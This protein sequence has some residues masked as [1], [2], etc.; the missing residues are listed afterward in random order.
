MGQYLD[1]PQ[2]GQPYHPGFVYVVQMEGS[3]MFK[4]GRSVD[5]PRRMSEFGLL[6]P[7]PYRLL[8]AR[9]VPCALRA[10][11]FLHSYF[12]SERSNGEW[13]RLREVDVKWAHL[14][15]LYIQNS[16]T[17]H[18]LGKR[19]CEEPFY[20]E[21]L[22]KYGRVFTLLAR[23]NQRREAAVQECCY[24]TY[25]CVEIDSILPVSEAVS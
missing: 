17:I 5:V 3:P 12:S 22:A 13:F 14:W 8:F 18:S 20:P 6:L 2:N 25:G 10:E 9:R 7:F 11:T 15:L 23:R 4:I 16:E 1:M 24:E 21:L 19:F